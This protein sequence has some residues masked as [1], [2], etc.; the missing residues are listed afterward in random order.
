[1]CYLFVIDNFATGF[2]PTDEEHEVRLQLN[3]LY[4]YA[5]RNWGH[6]A[7]TASTEK[8]LIAN[9]LECDA[10]ISGCSQAMMASGRYSSQEV[11]KQMTGVHLAVYFGLRKEI[12]ALLK[13]RHD[14]DSKDS[15]GR[16]PLL[17]AAE[18]GH[19]AVAKLLLEKALS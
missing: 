9:F 12:T 16:T 18:E 19:E 6:H 2:C 17:W 3:P 15:H 8:L 10:K 5:A 14:L 4:D 1:M 13:N 11:P 7:R